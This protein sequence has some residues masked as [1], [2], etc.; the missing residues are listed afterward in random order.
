MSLQITLD[1]LASGNIYIGWTPRPCSLRFTPAQPQGATVT[2]VCVT[3]PTSG[4]VMFAAN[5]NTRPTATLQVAVQGNGQAVNFFMSGSKASTQDQ[6]TVVEARD[7][8]GAVLARRTVMV[9]VRKNANTLTP[10]ERD[11]FLDAI[12]RLNLAGSIPNYTTYREMHNEAA[13][14]EIHN[15]QLGPRF[16]FLPWHRAYLLDVERRLQSIHPAVTIPYWKFD[17][18]AANVFTADFMGDERSSG[19]LRFTPTNP[20]SRW[21]IGIRPGIVRMPWVNMRA[22]VGQIPNQPAILTEAGTLG[23]GN[24][25]A[26]F[27]LMERNPHGYAHSVFRPGAPITSPSSAPEDPLFFML[28]CNVDRLWAVWQRR[29]NRHDAANTATYTIQGSFA[30]NPNGIRVGDFLNDTLWPWND[31]VRSATSTR[32]PTAPGGRFPQLNVPATPAAVPVLRELIDYQAIRGGQPNYFDYDRVPFFPGIGAFLEGVSDDEAA[33]ESTL[34]K[35]KNF[36]E[37]VK[38]ADMSDMDNILNERDQVDPGDEKATEKLRTVMTN[39][40]ADNSPR[41]KAMKAINDALFEDEAAVIDTINIVTDEQEPLV[42]RRAA[43]HSLIAVRFASSALRALMPQ[44]KQAMRK[45]LDDRD[46]ELV[47]LAAEILAAEKDEAV[48]GV[49][50]E[51]LRNNATGAIPKEKAIQLLSLDIRADFIPVIR[52]VLTKTEDP[53]VQIEAITALS[54]D[55]DSKGMIREKLEDKGSNQEVRMASITALNTGPTGELTP[56]LKNIVKDQG[57]SF[58]LRKASLGALATQPGLESVEEDDEEFINAVR[59]LSESGNEE[60]KRITSRFLPGNNRREDDN[61]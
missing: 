11:L 42:I 52:E 33:L 38:T 43:L 58:E 26:N 50:L 61:E 22:S 24:A 29:L 44:F 19:T 12:L 45:L 9:R 39:K 36:T 28:H 8:S 54:N 47:Q 18:V 23:L 6:D 27:R 56:L 17:E 14:A 13:D 51:Q 31:E 41:L 25:F 5:A 57:E 7:S 3:K 34:R 35:N 59:E 15:S 20:L 55:P 37:R 53:N 2:L 21:R 48:Q 10:R 32:P 1:G 49:L 60:M 46:P 30:P 4:Q 16:S 40:G